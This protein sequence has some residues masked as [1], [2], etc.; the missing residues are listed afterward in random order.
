[1]AP[2]MAI[3]DHLYAEIPRER[4]WVAWPTPSSRC[5]SPPLPITTT[6]TSDGVLREA[7]VGRGALAGRLQN[8]AGAFADVLIR[9]KVA[10][11]HPVH[12]ALMSE[13]Y[14]PSN[15]VACPICG[16]PM[17]F[18]IIRRPFTES[19]YAFDCKPCGL[20][21]TAPESSTSP[22]IVPGSTPF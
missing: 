5:D 7:K 9:V 16:R 10:L 22:A 6:L 15:E 20:S 3:L 19:L 8:P 21:M 1:M 14:T 13:D 12:K 18:Q 4:G 2:R 11:C 17:T